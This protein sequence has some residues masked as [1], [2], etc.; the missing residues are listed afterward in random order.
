VPGIAGIVAKKLLGGWQK[1][2]VIVT[3]LVGVAGALIGG[4]VA[5]TILRIDAMQGLFN[6]S[7][8]TTALIGSIVVLLVHDT[9]TNGGN[10]TFLRRPSSW[11]LHRR[12]TRHPVRTARN[13]VMPGRPLRRAPY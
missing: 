2:G 12:E 7:T 11:R 1:H 13:S 5:S 10:R 3:M 9:L 6:L 4:W 8:W